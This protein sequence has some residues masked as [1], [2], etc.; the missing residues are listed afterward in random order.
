[1]GEIAYEEQD[2]ESNFKQL[3]FLQVEDDEILL[4]WIEKSY[5]KHVSLNAKMKYFKSWL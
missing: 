1:M 5:D 3:L 2:E 4:K